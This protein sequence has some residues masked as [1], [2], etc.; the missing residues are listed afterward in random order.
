MKEILKGYLSGSN[1]SQ[2]INSANTHSQII[3]FSSIYTN[4]SNSIHLRAVALT[5]LRQTLD[6][7]E[8]DEKDKEFFAL[9]KRVQEDLDILWDKYRLPQADGVWAAEKGNSLWIPNDNV[10]PRNKQYNNMW[11]KT[12]A[13]IKSENGIKGIP[14]IDSVPNFSNIAK[15]IVEIEFPSD[16]RYDRDNTRQ[17]LHDTA[18]A[19]LAKL[20]GWTLED[21]YA[22]KDKLNLV[23]HE[24]IDCKMLYLVP[25]EVHDNIPHFGGIG[26]AQIVSR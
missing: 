11:G 14:Y 23:W 16:Y 8:P 7:L 15:E 10:I 2:G 19:K 26:M 25:R 12:W 3:K 5:K 4:D 24:D 20:K 6:T 9:P 1:A 17:G 13:Q 18:F 21:T 22:Y